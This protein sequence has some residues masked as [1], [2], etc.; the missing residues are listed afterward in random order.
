MQRACWLGRLCFGWLATLA[1]TTTTATVVA[2]RVAAATPI[3]ATALSGLAATTSTCRARHA[4]ARRREFGIGLCGWRIL[5]RFAAC[6]AQLALQ[7][8]QCIGASGI[9]Q[10]R[11]SWS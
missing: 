2:T 6:L 5:G 8:A 10:R 4:L 7:G 1:I 11:T 9:A 3:A